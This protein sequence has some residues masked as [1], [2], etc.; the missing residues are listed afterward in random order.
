MPALSHS[1]TDTIAHPIKSLGE[2][3]EAGISA[4]SPKH[5]KGLLERISN[6]ENFKNGVDQKAGL[7]YS[8]QGYDPSAQSFG[9]YTAEKVPGVKVS[10]RMQNAILDQKRARLFDELTSNLG[11]YETHVQD[12]KRAADLANV[13]TGYGKF[14]NRNLEGTVKFLNQL[15]SARLQTSRLKHMGMILESLAPNGILPKGA[16]M[17][18]S[19]R[20]ELWKQMGSTLTVG[21]GLLKLAESTGAKVSNDPRDSNFAKAIWTKPDGNQVVWSPF[22]SYQPQVRF[23]T[24]ML[25]G[26]KV[27]NGEV[28]N[29]RNPKNPT[30]P[31]IGSEI[32][33]YA[34]NR[35]HPAPRLAWDVF[36]QDKRHLNQDR[37]SFL[38]P[39]NPLSLPMGAIEP[40][41]IGV[42]KDL[43]DELGPAGPIENFIPL[44]LGANI[45]V[46]KKNQIQPLGTNLSPYRRRR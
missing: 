39:K 4:F 16:K 15:G 7:Y 23:A 9:S 24:Q 36:T 31:S 10:E 35:L 8:K 37:S 44:T 43:Y 1:L 34:H 18:M 46:Y 2:I 21:V 42:L 41:N 11:P 26:Q 28:K 20:T 27:V 19:V 45:D 17:P 5:Y 3:K 30:Q 12:Y 38:D 14:D 29:L 22:S 6:R 32:G 33:E 40:I 25:Y 13:S